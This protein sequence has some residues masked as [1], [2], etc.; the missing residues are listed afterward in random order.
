METTNATTQE[1]VSVQVE[2]SNVSTF[3]AAIK[4]LLASGANRVNNLKIKNINTTDMDNYCRV[5]FT[6][7]TPV[8]GFASNDNG[9]TYEETKTNIVFLSLYAIAGCVKEDENLAW[10]GNAIV[11]KPK[12]LELIFSGAS[13]DI[14]QEFVP[15][16][17]EFI[18]PFSSNP[19]PSIYPHDIIINHVVKFKLSKSG[20]DMAKMLAVNLMGI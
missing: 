4:T 6:L 2:N 13:V 8:K 1:Q 10:L 12:R 9:I 17:T 16:N 5:S 11:E 15:A 20:E 19:K 18:N 7:T 14:I 3:N